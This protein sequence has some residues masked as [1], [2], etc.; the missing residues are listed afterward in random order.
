MVTH[1]V[2]SEYE[3]INLCV[4]QHLAYQYIVNVEWKACFFTIIIFKYTNNVTILLMSLGCYEQT[5]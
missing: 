5:P 2:C 1:K 4:F 3:Q